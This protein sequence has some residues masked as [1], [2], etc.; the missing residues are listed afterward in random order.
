MPSMPAVHNVMM[1]AL[2]EAQLGAVPP[3]GV[4]LPVISH[5]QAIAPAPPA[6][7]ISPDPAAADSVSDSA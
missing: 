2:A 7:C 5:M 6:R 3:S 4:P 1:S